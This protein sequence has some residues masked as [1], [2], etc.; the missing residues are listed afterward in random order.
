[1]NKVCVLIH[2][3]P[4]ECFIHLFSVP[5]LT[6]HNSSS[7]SPIWGFLPDPHP[8]RVRWWIQS[9]L[10]ECLQPPLHPPSC[11]FLLSSQR[12]ECLFL[13]RLNCGSWGSLCCIWFLSLHPLQAFSFLLFVRKKEKIHITPIHKTTKKIYI[14]FLLDPTFCISWKT[15]IFLAKLSYFSIYL[16]TYNAHSQPLL[17]CCTYFSECSA[18]LQ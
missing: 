5:Q 3:F 18:Q 10:D 17:Q 16:P 13:Q 8:W 12:K 6:Y 9:G 7:K 4:E 2:F 14:Y 1:M 15:V 11:P